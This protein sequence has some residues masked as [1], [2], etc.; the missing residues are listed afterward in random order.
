VDIYRAETLCPLAEAYRTLGDAASALAVYKRA[1][2]EATVN[3]NSRPRAEDLSAICCSLAKHEVEPDL[4]LWAR[5]TKVHDGLG[6]P[7]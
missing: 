6:E 1:V 5:L 2:E 3:P 4:E 7:W